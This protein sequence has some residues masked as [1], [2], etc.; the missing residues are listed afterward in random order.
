[1]AES[2]DTSAA[3]GTVS[4]DVPTVQVMVQTHHK[5]RP[6]GEIRAN[7]EAN[8]NLAATYRNSLRLYENEVYEGD[9]AAGSTDNVV[10]HKF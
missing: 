5:Q 6:K 3:A 9:V 4:R 2:S 7:P 1:M 8:R 10:Q